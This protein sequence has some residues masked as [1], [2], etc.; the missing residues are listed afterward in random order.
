MDIHIV[1]K[2][3]AGLAGRSFIENCSFQEPF[4]KTVSLLGADRRNP[5]LTS[6]M[7]SF[8]SL[9]PSRPMIAPY[10]M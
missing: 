6:S 4:L 2:E 7:I 8:P 5:Y 1:G 9:T 10:E 3:L